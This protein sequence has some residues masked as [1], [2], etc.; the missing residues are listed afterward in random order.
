M[1]TSFDSAK[2]GEDK[3]K[4]SKQ[5]TKGLTEIKEKDSDGEN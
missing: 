2:S 5:W 4:F 3:D 1:D